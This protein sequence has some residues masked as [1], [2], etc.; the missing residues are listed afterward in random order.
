ML[1]SDAGLDFRSLV[2]TWHISANSGLFCRHPSN[3][4]CRRLNLF[5]APSLLAEQQETATVAKK[6]TKGRVSATQS[7]VVHAREA[8][9]RKLMVN[10][11][12]CSNSV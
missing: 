1:V 8:A 7:T 9:E 6:D 3:D 10:F 5:L 4:K 12:G 2:S 11:H